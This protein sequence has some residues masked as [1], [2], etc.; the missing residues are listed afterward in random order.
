MIKLLKVDNLAVE[1]RTSLGVARA[2]NG[3]SFAVEPGEAVGIVGESGSGKSVTAMAVMRLLPAAT[4]IVSS[5]R[6]VFE[7]TDLLTLGEE[8]MRRLRG[9]AIGMVFQDPL[10]ALNPAL[11]VGR[12]LTEGPKVHLGMSDKQ[13]RAHAVDT[14]KLVGI[15][16]PESR[17]SAYPHQLSGGM[18]QRV[19]IAQ[20]I[21]CRPRLLIADEPTTALDVTVQAQILDLVRRLQRELDLAIVW[22]SHDLGVVAGLCDRALVMYGGRVVERAPIDDLFARPRHP[23]TRALL[24][25]VPPLDGPVPARLAAVPGVPPTVYALPGGCA[26]APR[27]PHAE[28]RCSRAEIDEV[29]LAEEH[30][31]RCVMAGEPALAGGI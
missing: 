14:L 18:R 23:Y 26:F 17:L 31:A 30:A 1:F 19:M 16:D 28:G 11:T 12:Q 2:V 29:V 27:C 3:V 8:P 7:G 4:A 25:A 13:A 10:S 24:G 5:G 20:A 15:P 9:S 22:I 21:V 6:I